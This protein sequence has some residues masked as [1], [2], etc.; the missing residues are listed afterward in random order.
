MAT[1]ESSLG[2]LTQQVP[3]QLCSLP[4]ILLGSR[5]GAQGWEDKLC[6]QAVTSGGEDGCRHGH[7]H[8]DAIGATIKGGSCKSD[9]NPT[10]NSPF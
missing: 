7:T 4:E 3:G 8:Q 1:P 2:S 10:H 9:G 5:G 6:L